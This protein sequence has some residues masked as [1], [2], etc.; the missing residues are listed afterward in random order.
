MRKKLSKGALTMK[1]QNKSKN[2]V[3]FAAVL[4]MMSLFPV[5]ML[6]A[7]CDTLDGP[8]VTEAQAALEKGNVTPLLK[9]VNPSDEDEIRAVFES[10]LKVRTRG[11]E[12][13]KIADTYFLETLIRIHRAAEGAPYTGLRPA[14]TIEPAIA[15]ADE[16]IKNG[17]VDE[18]AEKIGTAAEKAIN[19]RFAKLKQAEENK[20]DSVEAGRKYVKAY[21]EYIHFVEGLHNLIA[22]KTGGHEHSSETQ[23][24]DH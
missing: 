11:P 15:A 20:E 19:A 7:H 10:T 8:L 22:G 16:A 24:G 2:N 14:G 13:K 21:V 17:S 18:L 23:D 3:L 9:W 6:F 4:V 5:R 1:T 12:A